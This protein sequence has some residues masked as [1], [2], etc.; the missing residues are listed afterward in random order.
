MKIFFSFFSIGLVNMHIYR[1][2]TDQTG[3]FVF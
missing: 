3:Q 1:V 2:G